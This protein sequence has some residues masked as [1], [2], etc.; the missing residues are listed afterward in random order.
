MTN[1][2]RVYFTGLNYTHQSLYNKCAPSFCTYAEQRI[3]S[4]TR[5]P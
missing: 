5:S 4:K 3:R 1:T 2:D